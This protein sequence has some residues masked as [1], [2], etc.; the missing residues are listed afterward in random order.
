MGPNIYDFYNHKFQKIDIIIYEIYT[1]VNKCNGPV[2]FLIPFFDGFYHISPEPL[3]VQKRIIPH[4]KA[5]T[6]SCLRL[7]LEGRRA[8][9]QY[10]DAMPT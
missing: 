2:W 3:G 10:K 7:E 5:L 8:W 6:F 4:W 9:L 1:L